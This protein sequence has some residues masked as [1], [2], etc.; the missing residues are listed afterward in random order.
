MA[1]D[2]IKMEAATPDK[3]EVLAITAA[4]GWDDPDHTV[5]KLFRIWRWFDQHTLDGNARSVTTALVDRM[6]GVSGFASAMQ[7]VG[8]LEVSADGIRLP[9]FDRHCGKTAKQRALTAQ[10]V[11]AHKSNA[12]GNE[13]GNDGGNG[14]SVTSALPREEKR[15]EERKEEHPH[16]PALFD[17]FWA[18]YPKRKSKADAEKAFTA[19]K[20]SEQLVEAMIAAIGRAT[21]SVEWRK[22]G[23]QFIPYPATWL[24]AKR[25]LDEQD[26]RESVAATTSGQMRIANGFVP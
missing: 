3:P 21:T 24:R 16:T 26:P 19:L 18:A 9:K 2:W 17:R 25:W 10:R 7:S 4:L 15:R 23:G 6:C 11:A 14:G 8:W 20:P 22:D 1:G 12:G 5:G 13:T